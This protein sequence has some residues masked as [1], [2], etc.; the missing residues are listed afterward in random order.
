[1]FIRI[2]L[3]FVFILPFNLS[4]ADEKKNTITELFNKSKKNKSKYDKE[5]IFDQNKIDEIK[6]LTDK[7]KEKENS[8]NRVSGLTSMDS[9]KMKSQIFTCW[10]VPI[11][12]PYADDM[13]VKVKLFLKKDGKIKKYEIIDKDRLNAPGQ[14]NFKLL[15]ESV[16]RAIKLCEPFNLPEENYEKWKILVLNFDA[17]PILGY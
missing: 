13:V 17:R 10:S 14:E 8:S 3:I 15:A 9:Y 4:N 11:G 5:N 6:K 7:A 1:M 16:I 12:L 2:L